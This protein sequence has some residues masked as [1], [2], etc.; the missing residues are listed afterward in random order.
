[1]ALTLAEADALLSMPKQFVDS[2]PIEFSETQPMQDWGRI[3]RM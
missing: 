1:M 2:D 3:C